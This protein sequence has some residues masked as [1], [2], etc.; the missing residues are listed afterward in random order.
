MRIDI[1]EFNSSDFDKILSDDL[2]I[3]AEAAVNKE[4]HD[5]KPL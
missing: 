3:T 2:I 1:F 4:E 5:P